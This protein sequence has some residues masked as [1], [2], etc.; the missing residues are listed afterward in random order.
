MTTR[1]GD[2]ATPLHFAASKGHLSVSKWLVCHGAKADDMDDFGKTPI[3]D[4]AEN[5]HGDVVDLLSASAAA[6]S[7]SSRRSICAMTDDEGR[8]SS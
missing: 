2:G 7:A 8:S 3:D 1:D 6:S 5:G 4:A